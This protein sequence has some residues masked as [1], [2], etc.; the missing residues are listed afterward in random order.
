LATTAEGRSKSNRN[1]I[2]WQRAKGEEAKV[3]V[4]EKA[5]TVEA[6]I[7]AKKYHAEAEGIAQ[8]AS[9]MKDLMKQEEDMKNFKLRLNKEKE[10]EL[11]NINITNRIFS[12]GLRLQL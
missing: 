3:T 10:I 4:K 9:S 5:G 2:L 6:D 11:A 7:N 1:E 8:K 12:G